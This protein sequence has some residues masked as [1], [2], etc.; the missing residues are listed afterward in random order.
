[1]EYLFFNSDGTTCKI[2]TSVFSLLGVSLQAGDSKNI[3]ND[4]YYEAYFFGMKIRI[5]ENCY[6]YEDR[7]KFMLSVKYD[8]I[9]NV[10][11]RDSDIAAV[12][13]IIQH[14][15][16]DNLGFE[17]ALEVEEGLEEKFPKP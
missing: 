16:A 11:V 1:M 10:T 12:A 17:L 14:L 4:L 6:D 15:L 13:R 7:F 8:A 9:R 2:A 3:L 5:E